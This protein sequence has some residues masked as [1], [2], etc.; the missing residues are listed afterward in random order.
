MTFEEILRGVTRHRANRLGG[1]DETSIQQKID[2]IEWALQ[3]ICE[4]LHDLEVKP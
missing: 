4:A 1:D 2:E 3:A